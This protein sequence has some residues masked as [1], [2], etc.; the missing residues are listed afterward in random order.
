MSDQIWSKQFYKALEAVGKLTE[1][2]KLRLANILI[3]VSDIEEKHNSVTPAPLKREIPPYDPRPLRDVEH[4]VHTLTV[5][6]LPKHTNG[7]ELYK[8]KG[9]QPVKSETSG[10]IK[11][12]PKKL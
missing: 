4:Y 12:P 2:E 1:V 7:S 10:E 8:D 5:E 9:Y 3:A 6:Q 11:N